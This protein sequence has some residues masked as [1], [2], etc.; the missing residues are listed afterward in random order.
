MKNTPSRFLATA[1]AGLMLVSGCAAPKSEQAQKQD[2]ADHYVSPK[3]QG[4]SAKINL[5]EVQQAFL[6]SKGSDFNSW[7]GAFE[8]R[9]NEIYEG[10]EI[11][12]IDASRANNRLVVT[13][14]VDKNDQPGFQAGEEKLFAIEQTGEAVNDQVP[15]RVA[16]G[17]GATYAQGHHSLLSNPFLQAFLIAGLMNS[18]GGRYHTPYGAYD[19]LKT[20]RTTYR[21]SPGYKVQQATN[22]AFNSRFKQKALTNS[23][24]SRRKFGSGVTHTQNGTK[25][26]SFGNK[27]TTNGTSGW[28]GRRAAGDTSATQN[29]TQRS[30]TT[31]HPRR[32][33][34]QRRSSGFSSGSSSSRRS[35]GGRRRR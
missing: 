5:D 20:H 15:L 13:G 6:S 33:T 23:Y 30:A 31:E 34:T 21:Q 14:F 25:T 9:V 8:K 32:T 22:K 28:S 35:W 10:S 7:M 19:R 18:W 27:G 26:R 3:V 2:Q 11:V 24:E 12:A 16:N 4:A 17:D 29:S 1:I